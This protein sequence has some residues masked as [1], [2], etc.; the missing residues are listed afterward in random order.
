MDLA[1]TVLVT[2]IYGTPLFMWSVS[3]LS[4]KPVGSTA[5]L[6]EHV[7]LHSAGK[8]SN[9]YQVSVEEPAKAEGLRPKQKPR[10]RFVTSN[11]SSK[12]ISV[13]AEGN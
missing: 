9:Q 5:S 11:G 13:N 2:L 12:C 10:S 8:M 3:P 7:Q 6:S 1:T 4:I